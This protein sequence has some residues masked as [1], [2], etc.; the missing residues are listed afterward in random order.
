MGLKLYNK[1]FRLLE[2]QKRP[3]SRRE[4]GLLGNAIEV[5]Q[6]HESRF[7]PGLDHIASDIRMIDAH[8]QR[9]K[10][11]PESVALSL[12]DPPI[13]VLFRFVKLSS[14]M[15]KFVHRSH[16]RRM[17]WREGTNCQTPIECVSRVGASQPSNNGRQLGESTARRL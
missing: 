11:S 9:A 3:I 6:E 7:I 2:A 15:R 13:R 4:H 16:H 17:L 12:V 10:G 5:E 1:L 14:R 8:E